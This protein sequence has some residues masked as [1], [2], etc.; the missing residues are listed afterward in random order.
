MTSGKFE[1]ADRG[2]LGRRVGQIS[3]QAQSRHGPKNVRLPRFYQIYDLTPR[4]QVMPMEVGAVGNRVWL[5]GMGGRISTR[6]SR[7]PHGSHDGS[8]RWGREVAR[9]AELELED[10]PAVTRRLIP[11]P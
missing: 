6:P 5:G 10:R 3:T 7:L 9:W 2:P 4:L 11:M 1:Q 8:Q